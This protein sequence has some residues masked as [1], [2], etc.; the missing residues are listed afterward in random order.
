M[1]QYNTHQYNTKEY[2]AHVFVLN[3]FETITSTDA[4]TNADSML[5]QE[6]ITIVDNLQ[7]FFDGQILSDS[8]VPNDVLLNQA[9]IVKLDSLALT[10]TRTMNVLKVLL[11]TMTLSDVR[12]MMMQTQLADFILMVDT[13]TK[14]ISDKRLNDS[15]RLQDW[16]SIK[17]QSANTWSD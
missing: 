11:E 4:E 14:Y 12:T 16:L 2:N 15:I 8:I 10:D 6:V 9:Q 13:L 3:L 5:R 17:R 1:P 7:K